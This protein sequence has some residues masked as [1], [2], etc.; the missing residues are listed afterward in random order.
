[1]SA[2]S[3]DQ[4]GPEE[5]RALLRRLLA[6]RA[7]SGAGDYPLA[8]GQR[9]LWFLQRLIPDTCAYNVAFSSEIEI[10]AARTCSTESRAC[11]NALATRSLPR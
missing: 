8:H 10:C 2:V 6:E 9:A 1:M 4:L 11:V 5:K 3:L 7:A